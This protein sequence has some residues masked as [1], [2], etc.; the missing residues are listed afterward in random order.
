MAASTTSQSS[1][2]ANENPISPWTEHE[3]RSNFSNEAS[4]FPEQ[5]PARVAFEQNEMEKL[6]PAM[7]PL[8]KAAAFTAMCLS[9]FIAC[10]EIFVT[11]TALPKVTEELG[12][13]DS[14]FV[15]IGSA[16]L[17]LWAAGIPIWAQMS[18]IFGRKVILG[19]TIIMFTIG[20]IIAAS[21]ESTETL[22]IGRAIQGV[23]VG[24]LTVVINICVVHMYE[25]RERAFYFGIVGGIAALSSA[26]GPFV[27]GVL[28][29]KLSWRW[30]FW[31]EV[32][33]TTASCI[34][35]LA[36]LEVEQD[37]KPLLEGLKNIDWLGSLAIAGA[38]VMV[39]VAL[40]F[41]VSHHPWKSPEV[42]CLL[43]L[44]LVLFV[45]FVLIEWRFAPNPLMPLRFFGELPRLAVLL[46]C[47]FQA[48]ILTAVT[49][50]IPLYFQ[51]VLGV[52]PLMSGV[53]F[54]P[55]TLTLA[56]MWASV[57]H[58]IK[59]T[60]RYVAQIRLGAAALLLGT[61][62]LVDTQSYTSWPRIVC[63]QVVIAIGLG[64]TYQAP[65]VALYEVIPKEDASSGTAAYQFL[66]QFGQTITIAFGQLIIQT[67]IRTNISALI[68]DGLPGSV[69]SELQSGR[70]IL[71]T[72]DRNLD[73]HQLA[74]L[75]KAFVEALRTMWIFYTVVAAIAFII[76]FGVPAKKMKSDAA[77]KEKEKEEKAD[78]H[79]E[80]TA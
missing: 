15:W 10:L 53:Y 62:L 12:A 75:R 20:S 38:T 3:P 66:K 32:P 14:D 1:L 61:G 6:K 16:Y 18:D 49:Y 34:G 72:F 39:L 21:A 74:I 58:V 25:P 45:A 47:F 37:R 9:V 8:R 29:E 2:R 48:L 19:S 55:T 44:G 13:S 22:I 51:A 35:M 23:G 60:G 71:S 33:F 11:T 59:K 76:S 46:G 17:L 64:L 7:S 79:V 42:V 31:I 67:R 50:F 5:S 43:V 26:I 27:G 69:I 54:L 4:E 65:L 77:P 73:S 68:A 70:T 63:S 40:Q 30:C 52:S 78:V 36:L 28:T 41:G 57:G 80:E 56:I 24:G